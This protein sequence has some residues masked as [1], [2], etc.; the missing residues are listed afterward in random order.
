MY[1]IRYPYFTGTNVFADS[2][3]LSEYT[4]RKKGNNDTINKLSEVWSLLFAVSP[5]ALD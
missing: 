1:S 2:R 4:V 5:E 3:I